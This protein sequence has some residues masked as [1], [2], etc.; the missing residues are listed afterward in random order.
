MGTM[1]MSPETAGAVAT[2][3]FPWNVPVGRDDHF[4]LPVSMSTANR[5]PLFDELPP[6]MVVPAMVVGAQSLK[7]GFT[8][9]FSVGAVRSGW[10]EEGSG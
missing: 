7:P 1:T 6:R 3:G 4:T 5:P 2:P 9:N 10:I 8:V